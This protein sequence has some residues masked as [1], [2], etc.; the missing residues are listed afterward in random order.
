MARSARSG[1]RPEGSKQ[2]LVSCVSCVR[3]YKFSAEEKEGEREGAK[4]YIKGSTHNKHTSTNGFANLLEFKTPE[5]LLLQ[6]I[7]TAPDNFNLM[8]KGLFHT[9]LN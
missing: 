1:M 8:L 2:S 6:C 3:W 9:Y 7:W 5:G 4:S